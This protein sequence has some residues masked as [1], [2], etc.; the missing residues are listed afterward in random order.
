MYRDA[1]GFADGHQA[2]DYGVRMAVFKRDHFAVDVCRYTAH[3]VVNGG[4]HGDWFAGDV[5]AGKDACGF[6]DTGQAFLDDVRSQVFQVQVN[7]IFELADAAAF[8]DLDGHRAAH[9]I[10]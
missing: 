4:E 7:V 8:A 5:H 1:C 3:V 6:R 10:A 2:G 9:D